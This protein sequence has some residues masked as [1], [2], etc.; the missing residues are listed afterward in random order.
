[1]IPLQ[2]AKWTFYDYV[3]D[4]K[5]PIQA[6][7]MGLSLDARLQFDAVLKDC[8][9]TEKPQDWGGFKHYLQGG[10]K[11]ER[12][13]ELGFM[14]DKRQY[15]ILGIFGDERK[16]AILLIGCYHKG[17]NYTPSNAIETARKRAKGFREGK[18]GLCERKIETDF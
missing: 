6:W 9:K 13:W 10:A 18:G 8:S 17:S 1:V 11:A 14:A 2:Q 3:P 4:K 12:V 7:H 15:R 5:N 16:H